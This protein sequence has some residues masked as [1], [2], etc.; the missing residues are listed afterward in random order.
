LEDIDIDGMMIEW[1]FGKWG[2]KMWTG[3]MS[4]DMDR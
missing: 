1:M 2:G 4:P 3:C